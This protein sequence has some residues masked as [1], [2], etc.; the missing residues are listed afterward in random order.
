MIIYS[1]RPNLGWVSIRNRV[2]PGGKAE[3]R[4]SPSSSTVLILPNDHGNFDE[5]WLEFKVN[6]EKKGLCY[7]TIEVLTY[8]PI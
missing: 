3:K 1:I 7:D 4:A 8:L 6:F 2:G 5:G